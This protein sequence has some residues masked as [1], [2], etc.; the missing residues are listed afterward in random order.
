MPVIETDTEHGDVIYPEG[1]GKPMAENPLQ[2][3]VIRTLVCGF[4]RHFAGRDDVFVGGDF[5]W[6]PIEGDNKTVTAPDVTVIADLPQPV[7]IRAMGSY[8]QWVFGGQVLV[9]IEVLSPSN[10][11]SEM[12][13][14]LE[15]YRRHG[16]A[17]YWMF[18]PLG[19]ALAV[20]VREGDNFLVIADAASG[21]TSPNTGVHVSVDDL[22]LVVH[23]ADGRRW[24]APAEE[25][26]RADE[27]ATRAD[28]MAARAEVAEAES[29]ALREELA[30]LRGGSE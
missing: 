5:F 20:F 1:D 28:E 16:V 26:R 7:D 15:F 3:L 12:A 8:R 13:R 27:M 11:W 19:G 29:A 14:K 9:A 2:H 18:D 23:G 24:L 22:E 21:W 25:A 10:T 30:R 6:Y 4:E 17:E